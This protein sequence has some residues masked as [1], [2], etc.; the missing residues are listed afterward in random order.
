MTSLVRWTGLVA[1]AAFALVACSDPPPRRTYY[2]RHIEPILVNSCAGNTSGCHRTNP[3]DPFHFAAGNFDVT[4]FQNVQK[5]RDVLEPFGAYPLPLLLI[6]AVGSSQLELA[7]GD[8]FRDLHVNHVGGPNLLVGEE[9]YLTLLTWME[10]GATENGL[11]PPTPPQQGSGACSTAVPPGFDPSPYVMNPNF[12]EFRDNVQPILDGRVQATNGGC[13]SSSCHGAPQSDFYLTCG[14]DMTQVAFNMSQAWA[15]VDTNVDQSQILRIPLARNAGG[16]PHTGGDKFPDRDTTGG[17][18]QVVRAWADKVDAIPFGV[19]DPGRQFFRDN[20]QPLLLTRGCSFEG[21]HSPSAPNDFK[22]RSGSEGFF[23]AVAL[24]RNY[25]LLR[26]EFMA[27]E[28]PDPRRSRAVAKAI[29]ATDGGIFHRGG[30]LFIGDPTIC[31]GTFDPM[32]TQPICVF[33]EWV[34]IER[35][36]MVTRGE[37]DALGP[38]S[39]VPL[40]YVDRA[41]THVA[42]P[43]E[44]DTYQ[45]GSD[46][47]VAPANIGALGAITGVGASTSLLGGCGVNTAQADVRAPDVRHDGT[48]VVFAMRTSATDPLGVWKVNTDGSGCQRITPPEPDIGGMKVHNFD[49]AWSPDGQWIVF[50]SSRAGTRSRKLFLP[51]SDIWRMRA[52]GTGLEQVTFLTNSEV[53]PQMMREGRI[54]MTTEKVSETFYQLSGRRINWDRTDYHPLLAQRSQ[55]PY[56]DPND[57]TVTHPSVGYSQATDIREDLNNNFLAIFSDAGAKGGAGTLAIFNRSVGPFELGRNDDGYLPSV[58]FPDPAATGRVG[59]PTSGAYRNPSGMT[60]GRIMVS[61]AAYNGDLGTATS[62]DWDIVAIDPRTGTRT[63]L[64]GGAGAQVDAVLGIKHPPRVPYVNRRQLVF[65]GQSNEG[66]TGAGRAIIHMPDAPMVFTLLSGNLRRGRPV[67]AFR[68]ATQLAVYEEAPAPANMT[69]GPV[70]QQRTMLGRAPLADDGSVRVNVPAG[71]GLVFELQNSNNS[72]IVSLGE[73][74]QVSPGE[75]ISMGVSENLF[76]AVCGGC[77]GSVSGSELDVSVTPDALTG[78]S[79]SQSMDREVRVGN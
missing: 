21:C 6:K 56:A 43:L 61:Y 70:F 26:D 60:D 50:A 18:Y 38:G 33:N 46:L 32:T 27:M 29:T 35:A 40:V 71:K 75:I 10:N 52:D 65:G 47:R 9:A 64:I 31:P 79:E 36:A 41:A 69:S 8:A 74:H 22:L 45:A 57:L 55:S 25:Q 20:V 15:F 7:Y 28:V 12:A 59:S 5:R 37:V 34:R 73:E 68:D 76:D 2:Q 24:E 77:H 62:F 11:P 54:T 14:A 16:G 30:Q 42:G 44:F 53:S 78:A 66:T 13:N 67:D 1:V 48:T 3:E 23:S 72:P 17:P 19:G 4:S 58:T 51:Q 39:T 49:P 63:P